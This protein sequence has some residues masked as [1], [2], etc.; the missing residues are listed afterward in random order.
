MYKIPVVFPDLRREE[1]ILQ[2]GDAL[3]YLDNLTGD[4]MSRIGSKIASNC[5][6]IDRLNNRIL[7]AAAKVE[8]VKQTK[9]KATNV[10][11]VSRYPVDEVTVGRQ[12]VI[13]SELERHSLQHVATNRTRLSQLRYQPMDRTGVY[14]S[15]VVH[16][17]NK[18]RERE[19]VEEEEAADDRWRHRNLESVS[20]LLVFEN[21]NYVDQVAAKSKRAKE[22]A[23]VQIDD[24]PT[25]IMVGEQLDRNAALS[26]AYVPG[27]SEAPE[28]DVPL[29]LPDLPDVATDIAYDVELPSIVPS[30][31]FPELP[32]IKSSGEMT[33]GAGGT[34]APSATPPPPP[35]P[36]VAG[37]PQSIPDTTTPAAAAAPPPPPPPP[38]E[39]APPPANAP[40][41]VADSPSASGPSPGAPEDSERGDLLA[42]IR[43]AGG[44]KMKLKSAKERKVE[45]KK[46]TEDDT[47]SISSGGIFAIAALQAKLRLRRE[48]ISGKKNKKE[49]ADGDEGSVMS[50]ASAA[51]QDDGDDNDD[52][53]WK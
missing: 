15:T 22:E 48:G 37:P 27:V 2:I 23:K 12:P 51:Q 19:R 47:K 4:I 13:F 30:A 34:A 16:C 10:F 41:P 11:S 18:R 43:S 5:D 14:R 33:A 1:S 31:G 20:S 28:F 50:L 32:T 38:P 8:R 45:K 7:L 39:S 26:F 29:S 21:N 44:G 35:P 52:E 36:E 24:A 42:S 9:T 25:S 17:V 49:T 53:D 40:P 3:E 6:D 46:N